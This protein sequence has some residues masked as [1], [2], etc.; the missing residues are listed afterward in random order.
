MKLTK[1]QENLT[2][3]LLQ[4]PAKLQLDQV[5]EMATIVCKEMAKIVYSPT[6]HTTPDHVIM[7]IEMLLAI[8]DKCQPEVEVALR[9]KIDELASTLY[10]EFAQ[11]YMPSGYPKVISPES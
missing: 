4:Q 2:K 7:T 5:D 9:K 6:G 8:F 3:L 11:N 10:T 1:Q